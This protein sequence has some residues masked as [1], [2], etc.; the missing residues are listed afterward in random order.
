MLDMQ[1]GASIDAIQPRLSTAP[2]V[3]RAFDRVVSAC[4]AVDVISSRASVGSSALSAAAN[5]ALD[6]IRSLRPRWGSLS[7][8]LTPDFRAKCHFVPAFRVFRRQ[9]GQHL[10]VGAFQ[11]LSRLLIPQAESRALPV[12]PVTLEQLMMSTEATWFSSSQPPLQCLPD[13]AGLRLGPS[14]TKVISNR[15]ASEL[16]FDYDL[17]LDRVRW[18]G[19]ASLLPSNRP[20]SLIGTLGLCSVAK[21]INEKKA[22]QERHEAFAEVVSSD[23][24]ATE[25]FMKVMT[26]SMCQELALSSLAIAMPEYMT[27]PSVRSLDA[28]EDAVF[29]VP[30]DACTFVFAVAVRRDLALS[31][32]ADRLQ[33]EPERDSV[34]LPVE[35]RVGISQSHFDMAAAMKMRSRRALSQERTNKVP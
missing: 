26:R 10:P 5:L 20:S 29:L 21:I 15:S 19:S 34:A 31:G 11:A 24:N 14:A 9:S 33:I 32:D 6:A 7:S 22:F 28:L 3:S 18:L 30:G 4:Y 17:S 16:K 13:D 27:S 12:R 23:R 8:S 2:E 25:R 1:D 35:I